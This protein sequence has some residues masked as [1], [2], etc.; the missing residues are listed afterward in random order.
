MKTLIVTKR[1]TFWID[2]FALK[3][4]MGWEIK[5]WDKKLQKELIRE[6]KILMAEF[7]KIKNKSGKKFFDLAF[8]ELERSVRNYSTEVTLDLE[9]LNRKEYRVRFDVALDDRD[10]INALIKLLRDKR[11]LTKATKQT[12]STDK[13]IKLHAKELVENFGITDNPCYPESFWWRHLE[14]MRIR[15]NDN[16]IPNAVP[17]LH[18]E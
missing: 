6:H 8:H 10:T 7:R 16:D 2:Y 15:H 17:W 13:K 9:N 14:K 4:Y 5:H 3:Y 1:N 18:G 11:N 12:I